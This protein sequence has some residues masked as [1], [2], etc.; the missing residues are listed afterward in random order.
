M[1]KFGCILI[2]GGGIAGL[3][4]AAALRRHGYEAELIERNA[5]W[6]PVGGGI[7]V[8]PNAMR[9]LSG[10]GIGAAV[11][12][13][14]AIVHRWQFLDQQGDLLSD[15]ALEPLWNGV[16][17]FIGIERTA[18]HDALRS[19]AA[20]ACRLGTWVTSLRHDNGRVS[21][22]F[23]DATTGEYDLVVGADGIHSAMREFV[24]G[25]T[26]PVYGGQMVWRSLVAMRPA[27]LDA[28]QFWLGDGTFFGLCPVGG[29]TYGF[30]NATSPR[31]RD[32]M[33]GRVQRLRDRFIGFGGAVRDYL[34]AVE[35]DEQIHCEPIEWLEVDRWHR[36]RVVLIGDAAHASS[37]MM[38]QGGSMAMEDALV[39]AESLCSTRQVETAIE[40]FVARR[41]QRVDWVQ[42]QS[43]AVGDML[44]MPPAR[45]NSVLRERGQS[46]FYGRFQPLTAMP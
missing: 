28:I 21:V 16:G 43:R 41:K 33:E 3:T 34:D 11:Q 27:K 19:G 7:A 35:T 22:V 46:A 13:A 6:E 2:A 9:V 8:Q 31:L 36:G 32:A 15:I 12:H 45:R 5:R 37:P 20:V 38:G 44:G 40:M 25:P 4:L 26:A 10:F 18:L 24:L 17:P 23:N 1:S 14:G 39:L 30:G 42:Q 29:G